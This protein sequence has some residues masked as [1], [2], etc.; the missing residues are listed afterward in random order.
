MSLQTSKWGQQS[1][2]HDLGTFDGQKHV[3][4]FLRSVVRRA[5]NSLSGLFKWAV[6]FRHAQANPLDLIERRWIR[7]A[8]LTSS[9]Y[10]LHSLRR[11]AA[12][13]WLNSGLNIRQVQLLLG[14]EE[15]QTTI[16]YLNYDLDEIARSASEVSFGFTPAD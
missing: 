12:K 14:H 2:R 1:G 9:A 11:F 13:S 8:G 6:R 7:D 3:N 5:L 10:T 15:L 16:L 4:Q